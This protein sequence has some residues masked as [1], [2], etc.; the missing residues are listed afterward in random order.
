[1]RDPFVVVCDDAYYMYGTGAP[2]GWDK[3]IWA[4]YKSTEG[5]G[6]PWEITES[7]VYEIPTDAQKQFWAPEVHKYNGFY[8]MF[9]SY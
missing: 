1:M 6:G 8:Y 3:T 5:L 9:A 4:C 7:L 2:N